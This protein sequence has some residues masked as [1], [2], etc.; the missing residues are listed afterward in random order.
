MSYPS[1]SRWVCA[2]PEEPVLT[3]EV[4]RLAGWHV[5]AARGCDAALP[6]L[7][8]IVATDPSSAV[9]AAECLASS[10]P[11]AARMLLDGPGVDGLTPEWAARANALAAA[12]ETP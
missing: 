7:T 10:D 4:L 3:D 9:L 1:S 8:P 5:L 6:W 12:L 11:D 2:D